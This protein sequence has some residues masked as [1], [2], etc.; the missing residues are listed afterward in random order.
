VLRAL[1]RPGPITLLS[2]GALLQA[3]PVQARDKTAR[4]AR[5]LEILGVVRE[6]PALAREAAGPLPAGR[7]ARNQWL[8]GA[9][10]R[11]KQA[12]RARGYDYVRAWGALTDD[13]RVR[14]EVD[15]GRVQLVFHGTNVLRDVFFRVEIDLPHKI[16][17]RPT[18]ERTLQRFKDKYHLV[19]IRYRVTEDGPHT[20]TALGR[21]ERTLR[22]HL[23]VISFERIGWGF[24]LSLDAMWGLLPRVSYSHKSLLLKEDRLDAG[25]EIALPYRQFIFQQEPEFQWVHSELELDY[26][27]PAFKRVHLAPSL[28]SEVAISRYFRENDNLRAYYQFHTEGFANISLQLPP[29]L[30][31]AL[32]FGGSYTNV[33][34][35]EQTELATLAPP[36]NQHLARLLVRLD[37]RFNFDREVERY[38]KRNELRLSLLLGF[39]SDGQVLFSTRFWAQWVEQISVLELVARARGVFMTGDVRFWDEVPL[40]GSYMRAWF[41][42]RYW[43]QEGLQLTVELWSP[44]FWGLMKVGLFNDLAGFVDLSREPS[45]Y[46]VADALGPGLNF[47]L[48][49]LFSLNIFYAFGFSPAGFEHNIS[50]Q[51]QKA[52]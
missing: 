33:F 14:I 10:T 9:L 18:L 7:E 3:A 43:I 46:A 28:D 49:D 36:P 52:L 50:A 23:Y 44:S 4:E 29:R 41:K 35:I 30:T 39:T 31:T 38:D 19:N 42:Q 40:A 6:S 11:I 5:P 24:S 47:W 27:F 12:Y 1:R 8:P 34:D 25:L 13:G 32:G 22:L 21:L 26:R 17:H 16:F 2:L 37:N 45:A 20:T 51:L 15:E 48:F